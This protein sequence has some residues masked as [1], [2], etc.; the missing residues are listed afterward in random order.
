MKDADNEFQEPMVSPS[1]SNPKIYSD[2][3]ERNHYIQESET[4]DCLAFQLD[5]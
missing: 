3:K 1:D 5:K 4:R 2:I